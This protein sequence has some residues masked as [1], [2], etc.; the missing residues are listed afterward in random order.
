MGH[1]RYIKILTW[2]RGY[3]E[4]KKRSKL[5]I[6]QPQCDFLCFIPPNLGDKF[7]FYCIEK[8]SLALVLR[9]FT[10][11]LGRKSRHLP[12]QSDSKLKPIVIWPLAFSRVSC[13]LLLFTLSSHWLMI[14]ST[15]SP[16][17]CCDSFGMGFSKLDQRRSILMAISLQTYLYKLNFTGGSWLTRD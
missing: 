15:F 16:I 4:L 12:N 6:P 14:T 10:S 7:D 11:W 3:G 13:R 5:L 17:G 9:K 8:G 2:L 1:F